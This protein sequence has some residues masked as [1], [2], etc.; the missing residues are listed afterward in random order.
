MKTIAVSSNLDLRR[1]FGQFQVLL[2]PVPDG[3]VVE[4]LAGGNGTR[5]Q[6]AGELEEEK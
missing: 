1:R 3:G 2:R 4:A 6:V 5:V